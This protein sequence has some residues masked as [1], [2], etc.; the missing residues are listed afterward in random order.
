[1]QISHTVPQEGRQHRAHLLRQARH[2]V[3]SK[4]VG[5]AGRSSVQASAW[6]LCVC[7]LQAVCGH[8][9]GTEWRP[10][11]C[12]RPAQAPHALPQLPGGLP[13]LP[14]RTHAQQPRACQPRG[15]APAAAAGRPP[16]GRACRT[17]RPPPSSRPPAA[18]PASARRARPGQTLPA[19]SCAAT[20]SA[21]S[22]SGARH[23]RAAGRQRQPRT[24]QR[25][26]GRS[27]PG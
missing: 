24:A 21:L 25:T 26:R 22:E 17:G 27:R 16:S 23:E 10:A 3:H 20:G 7:L 1:M 19:W 2:S 5:C 4:Q 11:P 6:G 14:T 13:Q 15:V 8:A 9:R 18:P 12:M